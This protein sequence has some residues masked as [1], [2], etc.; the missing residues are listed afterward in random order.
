M[1]QKCKCERMHCEEI[2]IIILVP[3]ALV[4]AAIGW[5]GLIFPPRLECQ[6]QEKHDC[7]IGSVIAVSRYPGPVGIG[8]AHING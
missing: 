5:Y 1:K 4:F 2:A 7:S 6:K 8:G 3:A